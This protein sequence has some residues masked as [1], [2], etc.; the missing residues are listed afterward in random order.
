MLFVFFP[1]VHTS[2]SFVWFKRALQHLYFSATGWRYNLRSTLW[3]QLIHLNVF[4]AHYTVIKV[5]TL[6]TYA[7]GFDRLGSREEYF[8]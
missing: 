6:S 5:N 7:A 8:R 4:T 3:L 1:I 2:T